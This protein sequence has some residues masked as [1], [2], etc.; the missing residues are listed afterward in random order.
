MKWRPCTPSGWES[1]LITVSHEQPTLLADRVG[2]E[3]RLSCETATLTELAEGFFFGAISITVDGRSLTSSTNLIPALGFV[4]TLEYDV[5]KLTAA[6]PTIES[7]FSME[8]IDE[9]WFRRE[10]SSLTTWS[11]ISDEVLSTDLSV[12]VDEIKRFSRSVLKSLT[13]EHPPLARN[14]FIRDRFNGYI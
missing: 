10:G 1:D 3:Y 14:P 5:A 7:Y 11:N 8:S 9:Y 12:F 6:D 2:A 4:L 13:K